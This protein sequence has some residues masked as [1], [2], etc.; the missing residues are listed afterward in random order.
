[1]QALYEPALRA[2]ERSTHPLIVVPEGGGVDSA[3]TALGL[4]RFLRKLEK[5]VR[6]VSADREGHEHLAFLKS[7]DA[8]EPRLE[9]IQN[10]IVTV[11]MSR[12]K[13]DEL[14][15]DVV[16]DN[17]HIS[18]KPQSGV[19]TSQ[20]IHLEPSAYQ[21]DLII[22]VGAESLEA[23]T[24]VFHDHTDFFYRTPI[25]NIDHSPHNEHYGHYNLVDVT[26]SACGEI[27]HDW[28]ESSTPELFDEHMATHFLA[29][30]IAKTKSFRTKS[31]TPRTLQVA[32]NLMAKGARREEIVEHLFR[33]RSVETLRLWGRA[34]A[35]LKS[36]PKERMVWTLLSQQDFLHAGAHEEALPGVVEELIS[37]SP[38]A[39]IAIIL[40]EDREHAICGIIHA[41]PP[42]DALALGVPFRASGT[43]EEARVCFRNKNIVEAERALIEHIQ[44]ALS[45]T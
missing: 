11:D 33:T 29:G 27:C 25:V 1:M 21:H 41:A 3:A 30:M 39:E 35:R 16:G 13:V 7:E 22:C 28:I 26:A 24:H 45:H 9:H 42:H 19:W 20:D 32:S 10:F 31:V 38:H 5:P 36:H 18:L 34:L 15:Y 2:I 17:L 37:S 23:C 4:G 14:S 8:V 6:I 44:S 43:H 40:Y 12:T